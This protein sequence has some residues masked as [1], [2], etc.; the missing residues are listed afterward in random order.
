M[1]P[2]GEERRMSPLIVG[3]TML[4]VFLGLGFIMLN[5]IFGELAGRR[6]GSYWKWL[7]AFF[8][9]PVFSHLLLIYLLIHAQRKGKELRSIQKGLIVID[10]DHQQ[11][12]GFKTNHDVS[13]TPF[14]TNPAVDE[15]ISNGTSDILYELRDK[16]VDELLEWEEWSKAHELALERL[17]ISKQVGDRRSIELYE[18]YIRLLKPRVRPID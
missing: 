5:F 15:Q 14:G 11:R 18:A 16:K 7:A 10:G 3:Y 9:L 8:L 6:F 1:P 13:V 4:F 17:E 12:A 2:G